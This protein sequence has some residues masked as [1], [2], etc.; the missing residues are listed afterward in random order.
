M[1]EMLNAK[2]LT[3]DIEVDGGIKT[4]NVA[5]VA[6]AG[7]NIMVAGSAVFKGEIEANV[8]EFMKVLKAYE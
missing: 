5:E 1:R 7:A 2:G 6:K 3:T 4:D 8:S